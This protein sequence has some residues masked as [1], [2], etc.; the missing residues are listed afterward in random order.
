LKIEGKAKGS[1][2]FE[3]V[4]PMKLVDSNGKE[5][6]FAQAQAQGDWMT[7]NFVSFI[8]ELNFEKVET[9]TGVLIFHN[10]NPSGLPENSK[11]FRLPVRFK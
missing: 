11:E 5:I 6:A 7:Y 8:A 1:W 9:D 3:A 4:F 10:D 2:F